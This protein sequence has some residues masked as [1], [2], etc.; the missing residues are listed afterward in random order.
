MPDHPIAWLV[1]IAAGC[2]ATSA[3]E[4]GAPAWVVHLSG[5]IAALMMLPSCL[6]W[7][8]HRED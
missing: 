8:K 6:R 7:E 2:A 5:L 1:G 3:Y 4:G